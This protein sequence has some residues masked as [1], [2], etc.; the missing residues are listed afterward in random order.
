MIEL[1]ASERYLLTYSVSK[2]N[3]WIK[4]ARL[5]YKPNNWSL[6]DFFNTLQGLRYKKLIEY[7]SH[8][9]TKTGWNYACRLA[10]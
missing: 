1:T 2:N 6:D 8:E 7:N 9:L 4:E 10:S 3:I 5:T